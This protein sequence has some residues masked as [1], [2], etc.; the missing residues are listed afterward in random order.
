MR[1]EQ[2]PAQRVSM[3]HIREV[4]RL[5]WAGG[6]SDR[7]I[8]Q[9]LRI[10]RPTVAESVRRAQGAGRSWP[11]PDHLDAATLERQLFALTPKTSP[12]RCPPPDWPQVHRALRR[13]GMTVF[14]LWQE[15]QAATPEGVQYS[16]CCAAYRQWAGTLDLVMRPHHRAGETL[17]IASAGQTLP[18][19]NHLTGEVH[20]VAICIAVLGASNSPSV[21]ATWSQGLPDWI[22]AP[23]RTFAALGGVP[24]VLVP[25]HLQAAIPQAHR[26]EPVL[27]RT[28]ADLAQ[29]YGVAVSPARA[30][31]PRDTAKGE[32]GVHV[33]ERWMLARLRHHPFFSLTEGNTVL[34]PLREALHQRPVQ[35]LPGSRHQL[36]AARD[37][38]A[39]RPLP[40]QPYESAEWQQVR[41]HSDDHVEVA[42]H[43]S[44]VPYAWVP[45]QLEARLSAQTV[46][47]FHTGKRLASHPRAWQKGRHTTMA[48]HM[49]Q[50]HRHDAE[51]TPQRLRHW[52][53]TTGVA[54]AQ[55]VETILASRPQPQQG[56][57]ACLG[58]MRLG[59]RYGDE[60]L[61][62]ACQRALALGACSYKSLASMRQ[63]ALDRQPV[64]AQPAAVPPVT[65]ANI[66]GPQ[67]SHDHT[68]EP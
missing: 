22:G 54:T 36:C 52:A 53:A 37:R 57:R 42:G 48:A 1:E 41:V 20:E 49:P 2:M 19:V 44:S 30:V 17:C 7:K 5:K 35:K 13:K 16:Q 58:R 45:H 61:A 32:V 3:R 68:G 46:A 4:F 65:P 12:P 14:L 64:P 24:E 59:T 60:R 25:D 62:A 63:H 18:V 39:L 23:V 55:V 40:A 67:Y 31:P 8:A 56:F 15:Y 38:P 47:L 33:V 26:Y 10:S 6:L 9:R 29:H 50:A 51:W 34:R 21:E 66:R 43:D 28:S 27:N 11:L